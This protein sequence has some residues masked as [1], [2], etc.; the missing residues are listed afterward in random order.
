MIVLVAGGSKS[1]EQGAMQS[2]SFEVVGIPR[3]L[4]VDDDP[5]LARLVAKVLARD[6]DVVTTLSAADTLRL[7]ANGER[8]DA[9]L[10]DLHLTGMTGEELVRQLD[11]LRPDLAHRIAFVTGSADPDANA[12]LLQGHGS[13][14]LGKPFEIEA[15]RAFVAA[16]LAND[17][18][19]EKRGAGP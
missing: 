2:G 19:V 18:I 5:G 10:V 15:L 9:I 6:Y 14:H 4:Y 3:I 16:I 11:A 13:P 1:S 17:P 7:I 12:G 8:F